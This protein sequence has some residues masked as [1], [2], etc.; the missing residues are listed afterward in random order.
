[1]ASPYEKKRPPPIEI[2]PLYPPRFLV[3]GPNAFAIA[4]R[5]AAKE[6]ERRR[7]QV[8]HQQLTSR[9]STADDDGASQ[10]GAGGDPSSPGDPHSNSTLTKL[11]TKECYSSLADQVQKSPRKSGQSQKSA[12]V[13][14]RHNSTTRS[15]HSERSY[16]SLTSQKQLVGLRE[17]ATSR[18]E[19][20]AQ[21]ERKLF[22]L[23]G[24]VPD[25]PTDG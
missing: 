9:P 20:E 12:S 22:K 25:T 18:A 1:M 5:A 7:V 17:E 2:P 4:E 10:W 19:I 15:R 6:E 13:T 3:P 16:P 24:Q 21:N 23:M 11:S 8:N 14:S